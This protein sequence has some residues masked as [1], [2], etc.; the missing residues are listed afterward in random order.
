MGIIAIYTVGYSD[1]FYGIHTFR[2]L[3]ASLL[4]GAGID[5]TTVSKEVKNVPKGS[6]FD[7]FTQDTVN[8]IFSHVNAVKR[9][10][11]NGKSAYEMFTFSYSPELASVFGIEQID[12]QSVIQSPTLLK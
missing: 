10:Q 4:I 7:D 12:P 11:F 3:H 5:P 8:L 6:S 1:S 2:H 9:K